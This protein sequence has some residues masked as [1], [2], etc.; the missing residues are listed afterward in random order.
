M[1]VQD[2]VFLQGRH[3]DPAYKARREQAFIVAVNCGHQGR[4]ICFCV[5]MGT[6][7][8]AAS[9]FDLALTEVLQGRNISSWWRSEPMRGAELIRELP[10]A[11]GR[12]RG[13]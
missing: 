5:S 10:R 3:V 11:H 8:R 7:P 12:R 13:N 2:R 4:G 9:G 1:A 6:G